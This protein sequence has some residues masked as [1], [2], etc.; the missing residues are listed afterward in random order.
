MSESNVL[1]CFTSA[2]SP[3]DP[4]G[5]SEPR[6]SFQVST[7]GGGNMA[8]V[9]RRQADLAKGSGSSAYHWTT[10]KSGDVFVPELRIVGGLRGLPGPTP[11]GPNPSGLPPSSRA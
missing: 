7:Q 1:G 10:V 2:I 5:F 6:S 9:L 3:V 4:S 11:G 8:L